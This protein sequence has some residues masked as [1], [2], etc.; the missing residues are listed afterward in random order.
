MLTILELGP[1]V[2]G[3]HVDGRLDAADIERVF[4]EIDRTLATQ[5]KIRVYGEVHSLAGMT[6]DALW[7]DLRLSV[8]HLGALS[9]VE[10]VALVTDIGWLKSAAGLENRMFGNMEIR[11]FSLAEQLEART[12]ITS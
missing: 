5:D 6:M 4:G 11:V 3:Y 7:R 9:R 2:L 1:N 10:K 8:N 12:W